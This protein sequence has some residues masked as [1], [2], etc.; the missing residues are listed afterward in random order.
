MRYKILTVD[1]SITV[2]SIVRKALGNFDCSLSEAVNGLDG[3]ALARRD[4]PDL[5]LLDVTMPVLDGPAMLARLRADPALANVPVLLLASAG[6]RDHTLLA[7]VTDQLMK[8]I[9]AALLVEH[10]SRI[11]DLAPSPAAPLAA[12]ALAAIR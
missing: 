10:I 7:G 5:I 4:R 11:L 1:D 8:P 6:D 3:L 12:P 9:T 2:R